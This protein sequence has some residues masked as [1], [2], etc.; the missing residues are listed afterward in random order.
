MPLQQILLPLLTAPVMKWLSF[1]LTLLAVAPLVAEP[2]PVGKFP[3]K[4]VPEQLSVLKLPGQGTVTD[5]VVDGRIS[6]G[7]VI[8]ILN[9]EL[10]EEERED[11]EFQLA[12]ERITHRDELRQL[13]QQREKLVFYLN[14][15]PG[16]RK[17]A[18]DAVSDG[19][20]ATRESL[21][22]LDER[23]AL[24][25]RELD[26]MEKRKRGEFERKHEGQILR[27]PFNGRLQYNI[28]LPEDRSAPVDVVGLVQNFATACD[29]SSYYVTISV[30]RSDLSLLPEKAF[31]VRVALPEGRELAASFAFRRVEQG[32]SGDM[33]VYFFRLPA[34]DAETAFNM[35]GSNTTATLFYEAEGDLERISKASLAAHPAAGECESWPELVARAC[36]GAVVVIVADRDIVIRRPG[37]EG[38]LPTKGSHGA[39]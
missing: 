16:E 1:P 18:A 15:S 11:M 36:P 12:K 5:L 34:E 17:Y 21:R 39:E 31:S 22:D 32:R 3:A 25:Q 29:D 6:A 24:V 8:A 7:T 19:S 23:I 14:L 20:P 37:K 4:I 38:Q 9:K 33:L 27:M 30:S 2:V 10:M 13:R 26:T 35:L 28:S